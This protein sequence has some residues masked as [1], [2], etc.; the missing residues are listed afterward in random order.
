MHRAALVSET[1]SAWSAPIGTGKTTMLR[2]LSGEDAPDGG[3]ITRRKDLRIGYLKQEVASLGERSILDVTLEGGG[4]ARETGRQISEIE[5]RLTAGE[6]VPEDELHRLGELHER[7]ESLG[8]YD[9]ESRGRRILK[10]L[11]FEDSD[12]ARPASEFSGGWMMRVALAQL[13]LSEPDLLLLD[14]PSNHLDLPSLEWLETYLTTFRGGIV[15]VSHDQ[16]FLDRMSTSILELAHNSLTRFEGKFLEVRDRASAPRRSADQGSRAS[17]TTDR[18]GPAIHRSLPCQE[19][20]G[21]AGAESGQDA[22]EDGAHRLAVLR[23]QGTWLQL[24]GG[25]REPVRWSVSSP[26]LPLVTVPIACSTT[27]TW[28]SNVGT[29]SHSSAAT[30]RAKPRCRR[31]SLASSTSS[32]VSESSGTRSAARTSPS[33]RLPSST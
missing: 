23:A 4:L 17:E 15:L 27:S 3:K 25:L 22:R 2:L 31:S 8:G 5:D 24:P 9:L 29:G 6:D 13:L 32:R 10:G 18:R 26:T 21:K 30:A 28:S 20:Q 12:C 19:H 7:M 11:G 33:I 1:A 16:T 14:E